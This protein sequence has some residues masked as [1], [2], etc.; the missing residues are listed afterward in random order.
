MKYLTC[1]ETA[2]LVRQSL[3]EA[4]PGVKFSVRSDRCI[5]IR[6]TDGPTKDQVKEVSGKF[7]GSYFDGMTDYK[8]SNRHMLNGELVHFGSD[9]VFQERQI[10]DAAMS[11]IIRAVCIEYPCFAGKVSLE[12]YKAGT[13]YNVMLGSGSWNRHWSAEE[14]INRAAGGKSFCEP[15]ES[16]TAASVS[17]HSDDRGNVGAAA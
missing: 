5:R 12:A 17:F 10:S 13:L 4:F 6:W 16:K 8:G 7:A 3:K 2:K 1:A 14:I 11:E 9:F 15:K